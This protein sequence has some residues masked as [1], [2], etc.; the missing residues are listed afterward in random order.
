MSCNVILLKGG[1]NIMLLN[2]KWNMFDM[3]EA[4][5]QMAYMKDSVGDNIKQNFSYM[6]TSS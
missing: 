1:G 2:G 6:T 5:K 3:I 4:K